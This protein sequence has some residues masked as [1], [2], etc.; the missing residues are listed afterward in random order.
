VVV[1]VAV[2]LAGC[3]GSSKS[4]ERRDA[5]NAYF[6]RV[7][8]AEAG[9]VGSAGEIDRAFRGFRL[10]GNSAGE[11]HELTFARDRVAGALRRVRAI[12]PP[13]DARHLHA[14]VV[15][16]LL[17]QH[18]AAA[19]LL[20][21]VDYQPRFQRALQPLSAA[22]ATLSQD[23]RQAARTKTPPAPSGSNTA[24]ATA[25]AQGSCGNCHTLAATGSTGTKGPNLDVLQL[26]AA[27]IA[28]EIRSGGSG[29][30][31][32][33][34]RIAPARIDALAAFIAAEEARA[35]A[36]NAALEAYAAAFSR[37]Q[38]AL[39]GML[40][41][42]ESLSAPPVLR[43]THVAEV[44]TLRRTA[45]LSG[46]VAAAL[47]GRHLGA[48]N[49]AIRELFAT[50]ATAHQVGTRRA[51]AAAVRAYNGRLRQI[52][53]LSARITRERQRLVQQVG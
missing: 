40:K 26:D 25:W 36:S 53:A 11:I 38:G 15:Q 44:R 49:K 33:A 20:A 12:D 28:A 24:A 18:A 43:P 42:L 23:I 1:L 32:F 45:G 13:R 47:R 37:Y 9:L 30:P 39:R 10:T 16:L 51:A 4:T 19:E 22:G 41:T 48:A 35:A 52:A 14:D 7:D 6:D 31:A 2:V 5:V 46:A 17:L 27:E 3:G 34:K 8:R 50:A 21:I 29:M